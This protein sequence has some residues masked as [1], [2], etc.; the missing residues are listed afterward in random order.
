MEAVVVLATEV[1]C[2]CCCSLCPCCSIYYN[3]RNT[4]RFQSNLKDLEKETK[5]L[6]D[7][8][9]NINQQLAAAEK[10]GK[11]PKTQGKQWLEEVEAFLLRLKSLQTSMETHKERRNGCLFNCSQRCKFS[12]EVA[13]VLE[14]VKRLTTAGNFPTGIVDQVPEPSNVDQATN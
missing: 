13:T 10:V 4:V 8:K 11:P 12:K 6:T 7:L 3:I 5:T 14:E 1:V 9:D 2:Y